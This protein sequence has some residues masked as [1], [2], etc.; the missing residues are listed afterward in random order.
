MSPNH[1]WRRSSYDVRSIDTPIFSKPPSYSRI[2]SRGPGGTIVEAHNAVA[3]LKRVSET[4]RSG[5]L[6]V[7]GLA[8]VYSIPIIPTTKID[9]LLLLGSGY[10]QVRN[11]HHVLVRSQAPDAVLVRTIIKGGAR[12]MA[13]KH[14]NRGYY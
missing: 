4:R 9:V 2:S 6:V 5:A 3:M 14:K 7:D 8:L 13:G 12:I 10:I 1:L 11:L